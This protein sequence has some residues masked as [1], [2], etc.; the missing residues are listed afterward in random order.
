M[1]RISALVAVAVGAYLIAHGRVAPRWRTLRPGLEI[2]TIHGEPWC[3]HGS[4]QIAVLRIDPANFA[5]RVRH[6]SLTADG[7]PLD[8]VAWQRSTHDH[9]KHPEL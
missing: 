8:I 2:A 4:A 9:E 5:I 7:E 6:Y 1:A 3:K